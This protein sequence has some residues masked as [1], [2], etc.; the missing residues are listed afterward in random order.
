M[1][2]N[3]KELRNNSEYYDFKIVSEDGIEFPVHK[4]ILTTRCEYFDRMLSGSFVES[5][6]DHFTFEESADSLK[7]NN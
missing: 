5:S 6:S 2:T 3:I 7:V 1:S 4:F